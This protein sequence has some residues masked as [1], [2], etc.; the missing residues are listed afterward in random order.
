M[1]I[2]FDY[3]YARLPE[4]FF[5]ATRAL[6]STSPTPIRVNEQLATRHGISLA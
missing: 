2:A 6:Q 4:R 1:N 3:S 5:A